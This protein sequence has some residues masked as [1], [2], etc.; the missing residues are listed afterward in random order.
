[1]VSTRHFMEKEFRKLDLQQG[2]VRNLM[3][4]RWVLQAVEAERQK[5]NNIKA[6]T[7]KINGHNVRKFQDN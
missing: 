6:V 3:M 7:T 4:D 5:W 1:M 2:K